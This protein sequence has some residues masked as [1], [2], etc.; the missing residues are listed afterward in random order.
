MQHCYT[1]HHTPFSCRTRGLCGLAKLCL[2]PES[3]CCYCSPLMCPTP[4]E[5]EGEDTASPHQRQQ[6]SW[7]QQRSRL[8]RCGHS[9]RRGSCHHDHG[10]C[11]YDHRGCHGGPCPT[12]AADARGGHLHRQA[13]SHTSGLRHKCRLAIA[14]TAQGFQHARCSQESMQH[15]LWPYSISPAV[16]LGCYVA[17]FAQ[18][19]QGA[20]SSTAEEAA[21]QRSPA[22]CM[23]AATLFLCCMA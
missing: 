15:A 21:T 23:P 11:H 14:V 9:Y 3:F 4:G 13:G 20:A 8:R 16:Q 5:R 1:K 22:H 10:G 12:P 6:Q 19:T 2:T 7:M 17:L 18:V